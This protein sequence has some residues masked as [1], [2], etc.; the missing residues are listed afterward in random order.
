MGDTDFLSCNENK[1]AK[2]KLIQ[3]FSNLDEFK[4][5][6]RDGPGGDEYLAKYLPDSEDV[7]R[8]VRESIVSA[9]EEEHAVR[10]SG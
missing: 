4:L 6:R 8:S 1:N 2:E 3:L 7:R 5:A 10:G 9:L